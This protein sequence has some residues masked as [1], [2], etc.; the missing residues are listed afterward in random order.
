MEIQNKKLAV[1][2]GPCSTRSG[3]GAH[4]RDLC[5]SFIKNYNDSYDIKIIST[6]WGATP[7]N[8]LAENV[9][10]D[11][12]SRLHFGPLPSKPHIFLQCSIPNEFQ[13]AGEIS[14]GVTAGVECTAVD[15][16]FL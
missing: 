3:Y 6:R 15:A 9:D 11:I 4:F 13:N 12:I 16:K 2:V 10:Q 5:R 1:L 14:I 7:M 8:A